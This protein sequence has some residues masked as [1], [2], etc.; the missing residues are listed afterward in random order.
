VIFILYRYRIANASLTQANDFGDESGLLLSTVVSYNKSLIKPHKAASRSTLLSR[1][2]SFFRGTQNEVGLLQSI[3]N[4]Q[5]DNDGLGTS[6]A[7]SSK[8]ASSGG[9]G[10][11]NSNFAS[12]SSS[13]TRGMKAVLQLLYDGERLS[14]E[15]AGTQGFSP[16]RSRRNSEETPVLPQFLSSS[17]RRILMRNLE[18][19]SSNSEGSNETDMTGSKKAGAGAWT[20]KP[21]SSVVSRLAKKQVIDFFL[22]QASLQESDVSRHAFRLYFT[23]NNKFGTSWRLPPHPPGAAKRL[24]RTSKYLVVKA[25]LEQALEWKRFGWEELIYLGLSFIS[26]P[27]GLWFLSYRRRIRIAR[28]MYLLLGSPDSH[29]WLKSTRATDRKS[30]V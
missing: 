16:R 3:R 30:V 11:T 27:L 17:L 22:T 19:K 6:S 14:S 2:N 5:I 7:F 29:S 15:T 20:S 4:D 9:Y 24:I 8:F 21:P 25:Y 1:L 23:G 18:E 28:L 12:S 26:Y 13:A 10:S